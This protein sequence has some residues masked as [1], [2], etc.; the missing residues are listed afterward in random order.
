MPEVGVIG[1]LGPAATVDFLARVLAATEAHTDQEHANLVVLQHSAVPDRTAFITGVSS[2]D[3]TEALVADA[4]RLEAMGVGAIVMPCNTATAFVDAMRAAV[5]VPI[6]DIVDVAV[7][8]AAAKGWGSVAVLATDGTRAVQTYDHAAAAHGMTVAYPDAQAQAVLN[9]IIYRY[10]KAG[11][12]APQ[13][14]LD[15]V[16]DTVLANGADGVVL[17]CTELSVAAT[18][19]H[20]DRVL[21]SLDSLVKR[22]VIAAGARLRP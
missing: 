19:L 8:D 7:E 22:T 12:P 15:S 1:G 6:V 3:P 20:N 9:E 13:G 18:G 14:M 16:I 17:G 4:R 2:D 10:V 5:Q 11:Q 21:D